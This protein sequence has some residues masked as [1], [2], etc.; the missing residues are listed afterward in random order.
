MA[1]NTLAGTKKGKGRTAKFYQRNKKSRDKK[2][3]YDTKYHK[4]K[5]R[6]AYRNK[7]NKINRKN[8]TYGNKDGKDVSHTKRGKTVSEK[9]GSNRARNRSKK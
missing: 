8:K 6:K 5:Y 1:R 3:Q 9:Q 4:S 7:L 2:K